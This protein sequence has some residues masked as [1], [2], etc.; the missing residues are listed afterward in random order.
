MLRIQKKSLEE[1]LENLEKYS[2]TSGNILPKLHEPGR[3]ITFSDCAMCDKMHENFIGKAYKYDDFNNVTLACKDD[4]QVRFK[5]S[6]LHHPFHNL[7]KN[8]SQKVK[9]SSKIYSF[10]QKNGVKTE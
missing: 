1:S 6:S 7:Y 10:K 8:R 4:S 5:N 9:V 3:K 2:R